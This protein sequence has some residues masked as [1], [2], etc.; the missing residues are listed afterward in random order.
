MQPTL[1]RQLQLVA[2]AIRAAT[3]VT[4]AEMQGPSRRR[5]IVNARI[6][7]AHH[8][9][10]QGWER[11]SVEQWLGRSHMVEWYLR[12]WT[13]YKAYD[14]RFQHTAQMVADGLR[15][16]YRPQSN[17][18]TTQSDMTENPLPSPLPERCN[19]CIYNVLLPRGHFCIC[20]LYA[21]CMEEERLEQAIKRSNNEPKNQTQNEQE[22]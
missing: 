4:M 1:P 11:T 8:A 5:W 2:D 20:V 3:G 7:F 18:K 10:E 9:D 22:S 15:R 19:G 21:A 12:R 14:R 17:K 16:L 13:E 6:I